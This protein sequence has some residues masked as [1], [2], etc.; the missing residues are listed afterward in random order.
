M[1]ESSGRMEVIREP[2]VEIDSGSRYFVNVGSIGQP[3]DNNP[4]A[5]LVI[6]DEEAET[7]EF[8]RVPYDITKSQEKILSQGLPSFLAERLMLAR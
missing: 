4:D 8:L 3:R 5:C 6:L 1:N 7:L 2:K